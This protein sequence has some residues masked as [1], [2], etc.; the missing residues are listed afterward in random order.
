MKSVLAIR[1]VH[2][3]DLG[4]FE[5]VLTEA[6]YQVRYCDVGLDELEGIDPLAPDILVALGGPIG[7]YEDDKYPF[8][9]DELRLLRERL[10]A[11]RP[12][13][14]LCLGSQMMAQALGAR[15]HPGRAKEIGWAPITLTAEGRN[16][17]LEHLDGVPVLHWHGDTFPLPEGAVRLASTAIAENQAFSI[18]RHAL[19][20]QFHPEVEAK[21][22]E[23]WLIGHTLELSLIKTPTVEDLRRD[24]QKWGEECALRGRLLLL[25]WLAGL[26]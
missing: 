3:E 10:A 25:D 12:T 8:I 20:L 14:G 17:P 5:P 21:S 22:I 7:V 4:S 18:G 13:L 26:D 11:R 9:R 19:A 15:V 2:F 6:G 24:T 1:H 16:S 23:R